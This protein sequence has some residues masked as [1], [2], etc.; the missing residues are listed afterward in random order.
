MTSIQMAT[1]A[2]GT[3]MYRDT[4][5]SSKAV[6]MPANSVTTRPTLATA[7]AQHG[8]GR[9]AQRELLADEGG[10]ALAGV[11]GQSGHH[12]LDA[13]VADGDQHHEE[14]RAV[15]ELGAG[16]RVGGHP[17]GVVAGVGGDEA[18]DRRR[19]GR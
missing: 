11:G 18:R 15:A 12:L 2:I 5:N 17:A 1:A 9:Q 7:K 8:E 13:D 3:E 19:P 10:Q 4:P 16:R 6:P 14:Q